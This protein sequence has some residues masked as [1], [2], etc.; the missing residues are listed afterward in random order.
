MTTRELIDVLRRLDPSGNLEVI[1]TRHSDYGEME[2]DGVSVVEGV[3]KSSA[4]YVM[5]SHGSLS[6]EDAAAVRRF[7]HF[8]GN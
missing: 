6:A 2:P 7:V 5:R 1:R 3:K 4:N 8:E